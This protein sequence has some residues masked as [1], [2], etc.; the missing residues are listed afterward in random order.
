[1]TMNMERKSLQDVNVRRAVDALIDRQKIVDTILLGYAEPAIGPFAPSLPFAPTYE[2]SKE[3]GKQMAVQYLEEAG[4]TIK[5]GKNAKRRRA[6][7]IYV[8]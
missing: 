7:F 6:T 1:M 4:Y 3:T 2:Q 8:Y 5:D